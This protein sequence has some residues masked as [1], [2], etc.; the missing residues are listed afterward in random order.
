MRA[1]FVL[2]SFWASLVV[3]SWEIEDQ[4]LVTNIMNIMMLQPYALEV[5]SIGTSKIGKD[6]EEDWNVIGESI[7]ESFA[8]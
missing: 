8:S 2:R 3:M 5:E 1:S 7:R 4:A 6:M